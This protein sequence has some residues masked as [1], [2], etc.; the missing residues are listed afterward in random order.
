M[1][2]LGNNV[3]HESY[4]W[5]MNNRIWPLRPNRAYYVDTRKTHRTH[6]WQ[7]IQESECRWWAPRKK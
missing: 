2:I 5:E 7:E 3:D 6:S 1:D 4:E